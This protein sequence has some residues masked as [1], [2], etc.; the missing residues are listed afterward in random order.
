M[1][2]SLLIISYLHPVYNALWDDLGQPHPVTASVKVKEQ[3]SEKRLT[4]LHPQGTVSKI[5]VYSFGGNCDSMGQ[6]SNR[7]CAGLSVYRWPHALCNQ[8]QVRQAVRRRR[9]NCFWYEITSLNCSILFSFFCL[10][11]FWSKWLVIGRDPAALHSFFPGA[12]RRQLDSQP[13]NKNRNEYLTREETVR[14]S[15]LFIF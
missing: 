8:T 7:R 14:F 1:S 4:D 5:S 12:F 11:I 13:G 9:G 10:V 15:T 3:Q 6:F 2:K